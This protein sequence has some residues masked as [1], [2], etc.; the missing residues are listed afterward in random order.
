MLRMVFLSHKAAMTD[1]PPSRSGLGSVIGS[2]PA[3]ELGAV[4]ASWAK[5]DPLAASTAKAGT[6]FKNALRFI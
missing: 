3:T 1:V 5:L 6:V 2:K 4:A